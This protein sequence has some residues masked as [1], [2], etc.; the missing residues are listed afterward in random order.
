METRE[1]DGATAKSIVNAMKDRGFLLSTDGPYDNVI[2]FKPPMC[3]SMDNAKELVDNLR[4]T[5][6]D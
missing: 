5:L 6:G 2:K 3:F 4:L 1:P